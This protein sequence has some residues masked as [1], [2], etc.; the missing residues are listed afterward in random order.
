MCGVT[1]DARFGGGLQ[2]GL[3]SQLVARS[4]LA[5]VGGLGAGAS[6]AG[7][8]AAGMGAG[9]GAAGGLAGSN[10]SHAASKASAVR[11]M[12]RSIMGARRSTMRRSI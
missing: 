1:I 6:T 10:V 9:A 4:G 8:G 11:T 5:G 2:G 12:P 7:A 3:N